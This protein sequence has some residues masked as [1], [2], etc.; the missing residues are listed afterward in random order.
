MPTTQGVVGKIFRKDFAANFG[1]PPA[2]FYTI[3]LE[4][5][6][7]WFRCKEK[8]PGQI[9]G[10]MVKIVHSEITF[11]KKGEKEAQVQERPEI[12]S[13]PSTQTSVTGES[14]SAGST[15]TGGL[16]ASTR[17]SSIHY[18]SARK[19]ALQM[20]DII[21]RTG[22]VKLPAKEA[23]K[24]EAVEALVDSYTARFF[25]DIATFGAVARANGTD[26]GGAAEPV[27]ADGDD[28]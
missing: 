14:G 8:D 4:G 19:D 9:E 5:N 18:Q 15:Q 11:T 13:G 10:K 12:V 26:E 25:S 6:D 21:T 24:L 23:N 27:A 20:V 3:K 16:S 22:A 28:E 2:T 7:T 1:K 17:E